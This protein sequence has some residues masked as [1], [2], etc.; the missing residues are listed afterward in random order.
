MI[1]YSLT[2]NDN[3]INDCRIQ[4]EH[5]YSNECMGLEKLYLCL[6]KIFLYEVD[7]S[8]VKYSIIKYKLSIKIPNI[9]A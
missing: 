4:L 3:R 1:E 5:P 6:V 2:K 7:V 9:T 8:I